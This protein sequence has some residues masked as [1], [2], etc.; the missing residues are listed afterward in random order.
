M[1]LIIFLDYSSNGLQALLCCRSAW[2]SCRWGFSRSFWRAHEHEDFLLVWKLNVEIHLFWS[3]CPP[4]WTLWTNRLVGQ[5]QRV[6]P[7]F[8]DLHLR[9]CLCLSHFVSVQ[10]TNWCSCSHERNVYRFPEHSNG[11]CVLS[12]RVS[13]LYHELDLGLVG[14][15]GSQFLHPIMYQGKLWRL[16]KWFTNFFLKKIFNFHP[17]I[18]DTVSWGRVVKD[19][20]VRSCLIELESFLLRSRPNT[21]YSDDSSMLYAR[22]MQDAVL[23][24]RSS[25]DPCVPYP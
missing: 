21:P 1:S 6:S 3:R 22:T 15:V 25:R 19:D 23:S 18:R 14:L 2:R 16:S 13:P 12:Q 5:S 24:S 10:Q 9:L 8:L 17:N 4:R 7:F 20:C 11:T